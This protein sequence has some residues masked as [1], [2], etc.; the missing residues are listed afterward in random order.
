MVR[1]PRS[2]IP[3]TVRG[4]K[5]YKC[6]KIPGDLENRTRGECYGPVHT[7]GGH[8]RANERSK[9]RSTRP[10]HPSSAVLRM[11]CRA[12]LAFSELDTPCRTP[13]ERSDV[14]GADSRRSVHF[15]GSRA[16]R[17]RES[18]ARGTTSRFST[19]A[20]GGGSKL[21]ADRLQCGQVVD[22]HQDQVDRD[23]ERQ[24]PGQNDHVHDE[25]A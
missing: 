13:V 7:T 20:P 18:D 3:K 11:G 12:R 23:E 5:T 1:W 21:A 17:H 19:P 2:S 6:V 16:V 9:M 4:M 8:R 22:A 15:G 14:G 10:I 24:H 25:E